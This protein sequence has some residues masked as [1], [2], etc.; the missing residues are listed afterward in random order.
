M[1]DPSLDQDFD[2]DQIERMVLAATLCI[3]RAPTLRPQIN[4]VSYLH[5]EKSF[6]FQILCLHN[7]WS[8]S[9]LL[10]VLKL[11]QGNEQATMWARQQVGALEELDVIDGEAFSNNIQSHLNLA[12]LDVD[13][14]TL[15]IGST[16]Q[17]VSIEDYLQGRWSRTSS[18]D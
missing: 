14:D 18:F 13:D 9:W 2:N 8:A 11:L 3:I 7:L 17:T 1:L 12:L 4:L 10:Q 6:V 15:S 16:E 5:L